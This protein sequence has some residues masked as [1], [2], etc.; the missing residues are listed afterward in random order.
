MSHHHNHQHHHHHHDHD[1]SHADELRTSV[2]ERAKLLKM[3]EHWIQHNAE[4]ARSYLDWAARAQSLGEPKVGSLLH[5]IAAQTKDQTR[6][7]ESILSLL[8]DASPS[9]NSP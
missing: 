1:T 7:F 2:S 4:H 8:K 5:E 9:G 3:V 6:G